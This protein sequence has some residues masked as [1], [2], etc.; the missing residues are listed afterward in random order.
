M[1]KQEI[2]IMKRQLTIL[3]LTALMVMAFISAVLMVP[4][5]ALAEEATQIAGVGVFAGTGECADAEGQGSNFALT[6]SGDLAGCWYVFVETVT[7]S[8]SGTYQQTG[9]EIFV[10]QYN[11]QAGTFKTNYHTEAK[12]QDC[13]NVATKVFGRC[14]HPIADGSGEGVFAGVSGRIDVNDDVEAQ[15]FPFKGHL[16][17]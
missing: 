10:G 2:R 11:G 6:I 15:T 13:S 9:Q 3:A 16:Q 14:Q 1:T 8:P 17:W 12:F 4:S 7:C 5:P